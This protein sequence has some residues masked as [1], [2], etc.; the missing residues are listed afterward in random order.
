MIKLTCNPSKMAGFNLFL[1]PEFYP[2]MNFFEFLIVE[3]FKNQE[4]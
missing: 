1:P 3:K 4:K 2:F